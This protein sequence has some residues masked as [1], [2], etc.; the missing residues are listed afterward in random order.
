M[1]DA[2]NEIQKTTFEAMVVL[3]VHQKDI[4]YY[5]AQASISSPFDFDWIAQ[6]RYHMN[7]KGDL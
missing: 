5:L 7:D 2:T 3:Q 1:R 4:V 6:L